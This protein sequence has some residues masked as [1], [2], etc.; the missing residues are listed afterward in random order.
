MSS[1]S[2]AKLH[3]LQPNLIRPDPF[4]PFPKLRQTGKINRNKQWTIYSDVKTENF[5]NTQAIVDTVSRCRCEYTLD[6]AAVIQEPHQP[7][8]GTL[9]DSD[10][11]T[12][13]STSKFLSTGL[14]FSDVWLFLSSSILAYLNTTKGLL[15]CSVYRLN[16]RFYNTI[17]IMIVNFNYVIKIIFLTMMLWKIVSQEDWL[18]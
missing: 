12:A 16:E 15:N 14:S 2:H 10:A 6:L 1:W 17:T 9:P 4:L 5:N 7:L 11:S 18:Q 13:S 8:S 3:F